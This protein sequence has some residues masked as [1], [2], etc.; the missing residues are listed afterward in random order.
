MGE[1]SVF[2]GKCFDGQ[3]GGRKVENKICK[4]GVA[5]HVRNV[6]KK[7]MYINT[8]VHDTDS[9]CFGASIFSVSFLSKHW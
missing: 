1:G 2:S 5:G 4:S 7:K 9:F 6:K 3:C 8:T